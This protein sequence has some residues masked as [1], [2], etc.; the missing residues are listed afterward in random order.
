M[1]EDQRFME[2]ALAEAEAAFAAGDEGVGSVIVLDSEILACGRNRTASDCDP[3]AHAETVAL[4][5]ACGESRSRRLS[6]A[7]C[8]TT[9]EPCPMCC[10]ALVIS[11]VG[12]VVMGARADDF[13]DERHGNY[14]MEELLALTGRSVELVTG[15]RVREC[16]SVRAHGHRGAS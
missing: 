15:V 4:R 13:P 5:K 11:G 14:R 3:T 9:M 7:T 2:I 16:I 1:D 8:Y 10:W 6:G 12:R